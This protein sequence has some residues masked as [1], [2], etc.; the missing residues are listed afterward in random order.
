MM[1]PIWDFLKEIY[2]LFDIQDAEQEHL[3]RTIKR[4]EAIIE[5]LGD[6]IE[7]LEKENRELRGE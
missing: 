4:Q 5:T 7:E 1:G 3:R 2:D 6:K